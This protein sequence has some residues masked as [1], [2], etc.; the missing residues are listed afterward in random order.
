M[1][2]LQNHKDQKYFHLK[3]RY[4]YKGEVLT[5][6]ERSG[7]V[8]DFS[9]TS[10]LKYFEKYDIQKNEE[11]QTVHFWYH[12][13]STS[14]ESKSDSNAREI[15]GSTEVSITVKSG[16]KEELNA[17]A[18]E[19]LEW[20]TKHLR[21]FKSQNFYEMKSNEKCFRSSL[22]T[23]S[24]RDLSKWTDEDEKEF[25]ADKKRLESMEVESV[26]ED[27]EYKIKWKKKRLFDLS[28]EVTVSSR[29]SKIDYFISHS[30]LDSAEKKCHGLEAFIDRCSSS[31][32][33]LSFWLD[34][35]CIDQS[36][37]TR[38]IEALPIN[39]G[40]CRKILILMGKTYMKRL[41]CIW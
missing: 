36:D 4:L 40:A 23:T 17:K 21:K 3:L 12:P 20:G 29:L 2:D 28:E 6:E 24:P 34:K 26:L 35:V 10:W 19:T 18:K 22:F 1:A 15:E 5:T 16:S 7:T 41:W 39:I 8:L 25:S 13:L 30:W 37:T 38:G 33:S 31:R 9:F 14:T 11:L 27:S 32:K